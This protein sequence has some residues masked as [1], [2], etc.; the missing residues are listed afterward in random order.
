MPARRA[1]SCAAGSGGHLASPHSVLQF[2]KVAG[3]AL[4]AFEGGEQKLLENLPHPQ[5]GLPLRRSSSA[6]EAVSE[7]CRSMTFTH[8]GVQPLI[9]SCRQGQHLRIPVLMALWSAV[10]YTIAARLAALDLVAIGLVDGDDIGEF[11]QA[12]L[13]SQ[14][15]AAPGI[16]TTTKTSTILATAISDCPTPTRPG[17][18][19]TAA[20]ASAMVSRV[21]LA[22]PP[23]A[24]AGRRG[25]DIGAW[26]GSE[27]CPCASCRRGSSRRSSMRSGPRRARRPCG[28]RNEVKPSWSIR[29]DSPGAGASAMPTLMDLPV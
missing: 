3:R 28:L 2:L 6:P 26:L 9:V 21:V 27:S 15:V 7:A 5:R 29:V 4:A 22:T 14:L 8:S 10:R 17:R 23:A 18:R 13:D 16:A 20:S 12:A 11:E 19:R 24:V 25:A 1:S